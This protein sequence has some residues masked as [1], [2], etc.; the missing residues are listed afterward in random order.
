MSNHFL[1]VPKLSGISYILIA[2]I[3]LVSLVTSYGIA[4]AAVTET[5]A[6]PCRWQRNYGSSSISILYKWGSNLQSTS[7]P[8]RTAFQ[9]GINDWNAAGT[10]ITFYQH[11]YGNV[12]FNTYN[13]NDSYGGYAQPYC[14]AYGHTTGYDVYGNLYYDNYSN[15]TR[16]AYAG[17]E[18][19]HSQ[20][21]GHISGTDIALMG[22]NPDPNTYYSP[23][24]PDKDLVNQVYP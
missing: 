10:Y 15:N 19:G 18:T 13:T 4:V 9:A 22:Y 1:K 23:R 21:I 2:F 3:L 16:H 17:H 20:S 14:D 12:Y 6:P 8:W 24:Q 11:I 5:D 7:A